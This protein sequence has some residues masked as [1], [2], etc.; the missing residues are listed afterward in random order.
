VA[1]GVGIRVRTAIARSW[2]GHGEFD[3]LRRVRATPDPWAGTTDPLAAELRCRVG[4]PRGRVGR[5]LH[6]PRYRSREAHA[7][8][9]WVF[10]RWHSSDPARDLLRAVD[11]VLAIDMR[12]PVAVADS[13]VRE[14]GEHHII[15]LDGNDLRGVSCGCVLSSIEPE[16]RSF[17]AVRCAPVPIEPETTLGEAAALMLEHH[18]GALPVI[19]AGWMIG[20]LTRDDLA[21]VGFDEAQFGGTCGKSTARVGIRHP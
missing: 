9:Q 15:I 21:D 10:C 7:G 6:C 1:Q 17:A 19:V 14:R 2:A 4:G 13:L 12:M 16:S 20:L 5:C 8:S 3:A 11:R 18:A